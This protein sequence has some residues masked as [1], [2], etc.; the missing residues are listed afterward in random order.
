MKEGLV[1]QVDLD[2]ESL[3]SK[4]PRGERSGG[5]MGRG[6]QAFLFDAFA[7]GARNVAL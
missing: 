4:A 5:P 3:A 7:G 6:K 2:Q 1:S